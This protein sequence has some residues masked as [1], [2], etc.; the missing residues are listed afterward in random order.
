MVKSPLPMGEDSGGLEKVTQ[1]SCRVLE[2]LEVIQEADISGTGGGS[3]TKWPWV[4][5]RGH[6]DSA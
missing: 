3:G 2:M 4:R 5:E 6:N 1:S